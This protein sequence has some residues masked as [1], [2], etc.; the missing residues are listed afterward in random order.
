MEKTQ[1]EPN[2]VKKRS[3][4]SQGEGS[5][6]KSKKK[7][8]LEKT[9]P[10]PDAYGA[11]W[12]MIADIKSEWQKLTEK[13]KSRKVLLK[14]MQKLQTR[15]P[16]ALCRAVFLCLCILNVWVSF[17]YTFINVQLLWLLHSIGPSP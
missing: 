14:K 4:E 3:I 5:S 7:Q 12:K 9:E 6:K 16:G 17:Y 8:R 11:Q 2:V 1:M 13:E 15:S 10:K